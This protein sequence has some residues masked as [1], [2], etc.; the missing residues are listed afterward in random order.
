MAGNQIEK[1]KLS[2][3]YFDGSKWVADTTGGYDGEDKNS[4]STIINKSGWY[5]LF[6]YQPVNTN[7][8]LRK[9]ETQNLLLFPNPS[10]NTISFQLPNNNPIHKIEVRDLL[11]RKVLIESEN[12]NN[13]YNLNISNLEKS[14]YFLVVKQSGKNTYYGKFI[15]I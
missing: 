8:T 9:S 10:T 7:E 6:S 11:G 2:L 14:I 5:T 13:I 12:N 1:N 4:Y 3:L 15:K